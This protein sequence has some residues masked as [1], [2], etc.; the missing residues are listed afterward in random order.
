M[1]VKITPATTS[2]TTRSGSATPGADEHPDAGCQD[3][4]S[5]REYQGME[6]YEARKKIVAVLEAQGLL[7]ETKPHKLMAARRT[8]PTP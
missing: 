7:V 8:A 6:R 5:G 3:Q 2:T 4:R 1:C